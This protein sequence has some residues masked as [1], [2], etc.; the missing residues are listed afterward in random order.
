MKGKPVA[1]I[2]YH[3]NAES[4]GTRMGFEFFANSLSSIGIVDAIKY[5]KCFGIDKNLRSVSVGL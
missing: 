2:F 1:F 3:A 4:P 5:K